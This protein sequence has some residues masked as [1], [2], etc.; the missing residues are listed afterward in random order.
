MFYSIGQNYRANKR[1][2]SE[3][4]GTRNLVDDFI[5]ICRH[6]EI[7]NEKRRKVA[8]T[9]FFDVSLTLPKELW[10]DRYRWKCK[11]AKLG[12]NGRC[13]TLKLCFCYVHLFRGGQKIKF[14]KKTF[15]K[16]SPFNGIK[17][18]QL[19]SIQPKRFFYN[20]F[21]ENTKRFSAAL[22]FK[23]KVVNRAVAS[24]PC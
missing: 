7:S 5:S 24:L 13:K 6:F 16:M 3:V 8:L 4:T 21:Q 22:L 9:V 18:S 2:S 17:T 19:H 15:F 23:L 20:F 10:Q 12:L 14:K 11:S 1:P